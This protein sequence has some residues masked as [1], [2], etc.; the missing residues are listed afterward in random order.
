[1]LESVILSL[2]INSSLL[3]TSMMIYRQMY[4]QNA[5]NESNFKQ[6]WEN[7]FGDDIED[8][9]GIELAKLDEI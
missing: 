9:K 3:I 8:S 2:M 4:Q 1:M 5:D 6:T 7:L